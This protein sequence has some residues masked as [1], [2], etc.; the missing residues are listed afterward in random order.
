M[1]SLA[2][3]EAAEADGALGAS[4][5]S[6]IVHGASI[7]DSS[8]TGYLIGQISLQFS[9][10][11]MLLMAEASLLLRRSLAVIRTTRTL[12]FDPTPQPQIPNNTLS[13]SW[14]NSWSQV[15]P[16]DL[17]HCPEGWNCHSSLST[18]LHRVIFG[19]RCSMGLFQQ[20]TGVR[21]RPWSPAHPQQCPSRNW[22]LRQLQDRAVGQSGP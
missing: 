1:L 19:E 2:G 20:S 7:L 18:A 6:L 5:P 10:P 22:S 9:P 16:G 15:E 13:P 11:A 4:S 17:P 8:P 3:R 12:G 14:R 21:G